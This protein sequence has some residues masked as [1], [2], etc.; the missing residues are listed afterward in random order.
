MAY[1]AVVATML[2]SWARVLHV[3]HVHRR[4]YQ[5]KLQVT[6]ENPGQHN[7]SLTYP[8]Q[9]CLSLGIGAAQQKTTYVSDIVPW[10]YA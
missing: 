3:W 7:G 2:L 9:T 8:A 10:C 1:L 6:S 5:G 4:P